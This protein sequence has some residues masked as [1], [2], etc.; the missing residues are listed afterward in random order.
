MSLDLLVGYAGMV[1]LGH[2]AFLAVGA[3][4]TAALTVF[5]EWPVIPAT[6]VAVI[7][8]AAV[9]AL[10]G[11]FA[12][13]LGGV[14][15]IM[16]TLAIGQMCYAYFF[17]ARDFGADD[18]MSGIPRP[19]FSSVGLDADDPMVFS[20]LIIAVTV[21]V[22][23]LLRVLVRSP[24]GAMLVALHQNENRMR[25]LGCPVLRYKWA[26]YVIAGAVAGLAGALVA[27][28]TG[29]VSPDLAFWTVSGEVLIMVI[30]GG[31]GSLVGAIAGAAVLVW[32][33]HT[34]SDA[35]T[36]ESAG[37]PGHF[38]DFWQFILG[39]FFVTV[40]LL[41]GDGLYGRIRWLWRRA[42]GQATP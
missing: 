13:R 18:G 11:A 34:L 39:L 20:A 3:Y 10:L 2:A 7:A 4:T 12:V 37:L 1:S 38:A 26:A 42:R 17:K 27:Q 32:L 22:Y 8:A 6:V 21:A 14:F 16:I 5:L 35:A 31:M 30:V 40:V 29:F 41:A 28:H 9:A 15:F 33:R 25:A 36:W 24:F 23:V 19:D